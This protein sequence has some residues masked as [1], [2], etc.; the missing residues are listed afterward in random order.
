MAA[1]TPRKIYE[2]AGA[3]DPKLAILN[4]LGKALD[5]VKTC[6]RLIL[7]GTYIAPQK[8]EGT[9]L[10]RPDSSVTEDLWMGNM[11]LVLQKGPMAF[12]DDEFVQFGGLDPEIHDWIL[13]RYSDAWEFHLNGVSV[14]SVED[15]AVRHIV[16][17]PG[18][19]ASKPIIAAFND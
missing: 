12:R 9:S 19:I 16:K 18:L 14:R 13:F 8:F 7:V 11:G 2:M 10:Y 15:R 3:S 5:D 4:A 6:G 17:K 1:I